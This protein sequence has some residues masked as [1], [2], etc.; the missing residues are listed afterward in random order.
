MNRLL[1]LGALLFLVGS[2]VGC[3][4]GEGE[5][6]PVANDSCPETGMKTCGLDDAQ[7]SA[8]L[9]CS[10]IPRNWMVSEVCATRC[11]FNGLMGAMCEYLEGDTGGDDTPTIADVIDPEDVPDIKEP[12]EL[13]GSDTPDVEEPYEV[14]FKDLMPDMTPPWVE[15]TIPADDAM[16]VSV[17]F[18][19]QITFTEPL[20]AVTVAES[21]VKLFDV[22]GDQ[23]PVEI[24]W[25]DEKKTVVKLTPAGAVFNSS[26][27][28]VTLDPMIKDL[29]GN[30]MGNS[31]EFTFYTAAIPTLGT[32]KTLAGK[33]A[34]L[35][36]QA[37]NTES[38]QYDYLT[39]F[40]FDGDWVAENNVISVKNASKFE[41]SLY[42]SVTETKSHFF[43]TY[44][45]FYPYRFA[46][47][48]DDRFGNDVSGGLV[49]VRKID[50]APLAVETYFK[51]DND[52]R[53]FSFVTEESGLVTAGKTFTDFHFDG[54]YPAATLF[55][56]GR[57]VGYL[58]SRKHESCLWLDENNGFLDGCILN[59][60]VKNSMQKIE[61]VFKDGMVDALSKE[62]GK[63]P[64]AKQSVG[65][66]L[67]HLLDSWWVRRTDVGQAQMWASEYTYEPHN[68]TIYQNRPDLSHPVP[69]VFVDP[70]ETD[71]GRPPWAWKY[72]PQNGTTFYDMARGVWFLDPAVHFKQRHDQ[73]NLWSDFDTEAGTGWSLEYCFNPY[74]SLDFRGIWAE[75]TTE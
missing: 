2:A 55:P 52:E 62:G 28:R 15:A 40:D 10:K 67:V 63:Y 51:K 29:A 73:S 38:P 24:E 42:Y 30:M 16:G 34:P 71:N 1:S 65:Y 69:S 13:P 7:Q 32:Y 37:T 8:V 20:H 21:T 74:F 31:Y 68:S 9:V 53:S 36:Y 23:I 54:L 4:D 43:I 70:E 11:V 35:L 57:Y 56:D 33:Y 72:N 47:E 26:P 19:I 22:T 66:G 59:A 61:Y 48:E 60:G 46:E 27:Y 49:V 45:F 41:A 5:V 75:C 39:R 64:Q 12:E 44:S 3:G 14:I 6:L 58:S 17:P 50:E 25:L 18:N